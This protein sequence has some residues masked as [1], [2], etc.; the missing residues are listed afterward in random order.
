M[1]RIGW[2][3]RSIRVRVIVAVVLILAGALGLWH[4]RTATL[5]RAGSLGAAEKPRTA[6]RKQVADA[7]PP[8]TI[9]GALAA[10]SVQERP[11][12]QSRER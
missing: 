12:N 6:V 2:S 10:Y 1:G 3:R 8:K 9:T 11:S 4:D 7:G 5:T